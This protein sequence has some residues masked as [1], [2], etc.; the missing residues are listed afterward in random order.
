MSS[1]LSRRAA[2]EKWKQKLGSSATYSNLIGVFERAGYQG[3][4]DTVHKVL[5]E[6]P[7]ILYTE[8]VRNFSGKSHHHKIQGGVYVDHTHR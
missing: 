2:L 1:L 7:P 3:Y 8:V 5:R 6:S 4:A